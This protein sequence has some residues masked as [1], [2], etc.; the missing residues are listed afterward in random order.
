MA[1]KSFLAFPFSFALRISTFIWESIRIAEAA[2]ININHAYKYLLISSVHEREL[3]KTYLQVI[4][5]VIATMIRMRRPASSLS[6]KYSFFFPKIKCPPSHHIHKIKLHI[7]CLRRR[8]PRK[9]AMTFNQR[10]YN[11]MSP[12]QS[13]RI[14]DLIINVHIISFRKCFRNFAE[15]EVEPGFHI[16]VDEYH[17]FRLQIC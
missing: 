4:W 14:Y 2:P 11:T 8:V 6:D 16:E 15:H 17:A 7:A 3:L 5:H 9:Q 1:L 10:K 13:F 12:E